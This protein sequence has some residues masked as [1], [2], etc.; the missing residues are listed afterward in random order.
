MVNRWTRTQIFLLRAP[1]RRDV[2]QKLLLCFSNRKTES[3]SRPGWGVN[4]WSYSFTESRQQIMR[5]SWATLKFYHRYSPSAAFGRPILSPSWA[6]TPFY[7]NK[8]AKMC[9][10]NPPK[11]RFLWPICLTC[12]VDLKVGGFVGDVAH[13]FNSWAFDRDLGGVAERL[14]DIHLEWTLGNCL[15]SKQHRHLG[16]RKNKSSSE[17]KRLV[18]AR[19]PTPGTHLVRPDDLRD[20]GDGVRLLAL[21]WLRLQLMETRGESI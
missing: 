11:G 9:N 21:I 7:S 2:V 3:N 14:I 20:V 13:W 5:V 19:L 16:N 6:T 15:A 17:W 18:M 12:S 10:K 1:Q 8:Y 4:V